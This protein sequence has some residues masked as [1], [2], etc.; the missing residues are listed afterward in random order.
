MGYVPYVSFGARQG[1][2]AGEGDRMK[3][4]A[5]KVVDY[6]T[7]VQLTAGQTTG[8]FTDKDF[9]AHTPKGDITFS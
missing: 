1:L 8:N 2:N 6:G 5:P 7:L 4:E 3:Y 9:P